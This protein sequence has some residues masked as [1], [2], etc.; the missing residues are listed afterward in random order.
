MRHKH[1]P[2]QL[3]QVIVFVALLTFGVLVGTYEML[4]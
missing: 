3:I 4:F 1:N 2:P